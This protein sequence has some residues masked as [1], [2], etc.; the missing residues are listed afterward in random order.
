MTRT[1]K[2]TVVVY[3]AGQLPVESYWSHFPAAMDFAKKIFLLKAVLKVKIWN[4]DNREPVNNAV[5]STDPAL[6][7]Y[8][9]KDGEY[10]ISFTFKNNPD[11]TQKTIS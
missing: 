3:E 11:E 10:A 1:I 4:G 8:L 6:L 7:F 5:I 2:Y 9:D